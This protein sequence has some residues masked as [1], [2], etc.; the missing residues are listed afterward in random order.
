MRAMA[1]IISDMLRTMVICAITL[2]VIYLACT[3]HERAMEALVVTFVS[4][5][6]YLFGERSA[7]KIPGQQEPH[8]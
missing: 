6:S 2:T 1:T 8:R 7:L 4:L 3:G 5:L